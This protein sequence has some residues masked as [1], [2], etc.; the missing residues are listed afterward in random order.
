M[1]STWVTQQDDADDFPFR[2]GFTT[3]ISNSTQVRSRNFL[4]FALHTLISV[5]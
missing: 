2:V 1:D 5:V 4:L 3:L